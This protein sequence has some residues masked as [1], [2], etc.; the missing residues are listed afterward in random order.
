MKEISDPA[1]VQRYYQA[2]QIRH[3]HSNSLIETQ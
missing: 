2:A 3:V 1:A